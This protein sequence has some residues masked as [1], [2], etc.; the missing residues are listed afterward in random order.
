MR[1]G[2]PRPQGDGMPGIRR[3]RVLAVAA[4]GL[5]AGCTGQASTGSPRPAADPLVATPPAHAVVAAY[6]L[7]VEGREAV[8]DLLRGLTDRAAAAGGAGREVLLGLGAGLFDRAGLAERR[9]RQLTAMPSFPG[10]VLDPGRTHGDLLVHVGAGTTPDAARLLA[11][12]AGPLAP[13]WRV[14]GFRDGAGTSPAGRPTALNPFHFT[15]GHGNPEAAVVPAEIRVGAGEPAWAAGGT[16]QVVRVIRLATRMWDHD[17]VDEQERI[18]GR[19]RDGTWLDGSPLAQDP[20]FDRDPGGAVTPLDAHVRL[21]RGAGERPPMLRR[22]Y[23][24]RAGEEDGLLFM[25][26]QKDLDRGFAGVQRRLA[27]ERLARY[28]LPVGGGY[29]FTPPPGTAWPTALFGP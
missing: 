8:G 2:E 16:Y 20:P 28:V 4:A 29:F 14:E 11:T 26:Y 5:V 6:R 15:E 9:P 27:G 12:V 23:S 22:G 24:Y 3:R 19:R 25:A 7:P 18:I 17:P 21:A 13:N 1:Q 10:D